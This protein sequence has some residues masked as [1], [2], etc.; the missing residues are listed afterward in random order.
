MKT[1][2]QSKAQ[3]EGK[4]ILCL[5]NDKLFVINQSMSCLDQLT[6]TG[7]T[8]Q[9]KSLVSICWE[10]R[11]ELLQKAIKTR[12]QDKHFALKLAYHKAEALQ[13]FMAEFAIYFPDSFGTYERNLLEQIK[14]ELHPQLL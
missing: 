2:K 14:N 10:L 3:E 8:K 6:I 13:K 5:N 9:F 12:T 7:V 1:K 4:I 11:T